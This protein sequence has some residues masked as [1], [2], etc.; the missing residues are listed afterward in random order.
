M[1]LAAGPISTC[2]CANQ[3]VMGWNGVC[4]HHSTFMFRFSDP[5]SR[6]VR[7]RR[8]CVC[9]ASAFASVGTATSNAARRRP[10]S[11]ACAGRSSELVRANPSPTVDERQEMSGL[12]VL[13]DGATLLQ[14]EEWPARTTSDI[15]ATTRTFRRSYAVAASRTRPSRR[16]AAGRTKPL[17]EQGPLTIL[18]RRHLV[19]PHTRGDR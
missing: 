9:S 10:R 3:I 1:L 8:R 4:H 17:R 6:P 19:R 11:H 18:G 2:H 7:Y 16:R 12:H 15:T 13:A 14:N 5:S